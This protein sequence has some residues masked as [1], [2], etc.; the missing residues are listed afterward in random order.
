MKKI[1]ILS[2]LCT[3]PSAIKM[4]A[5]VL[6]LEKNPAFESVVCIT[7]QHR[8]M[9]DQVLNLFEIKSDYNLNIMQ[10]NQDLYSITAN[11]LNGLKPILTDLKPDCVI[12]QGDTTSMM[13]A[14]LAAFYQKIPVAHVEAGLRTNN[15]YAPYPEEVN[16][17]I[18]T[19]IVQL[20]FA[21]TEI[22]KNNLLRENVNPE[23]IFVTGNTVIDA[24]LWVRDKANKINDFSNCLG[25]TI[26]NLINHN[27]N[28]ILI[29]CHRRESFGDGFQ[30][31][32][33][34][35]KTL[36]EKYPDWH[37]IYPVHLNPNVQKPVY[38]TL[39]SIAN[40][41][42][43]SPLE[44]VPFVYLMDKSKIIITDSGGIQEEAPSLGKP[45]LVTR[46][47]TE[48][49]EGVQ[50]GAVIL[51][52]TNTQ[53]IIKEAE[54]LMHDKARYAKMSTI[55]NP[56]GDGLSA[57]RIVQTLEKISKKT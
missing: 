38:E 3:R 45:V 2:I 21:P 19:R 4:A 28:I 29:T 1:K 13:A 46:D 30:N 24:L 35:F 15:I 10:P 53:N 52:G 36:A 55:R 34:A 12:V 50:A 14:A 43:I 23:N 56:Y 22:S 11:V 25:P 5:I 48:R 9:L 41:H 42:L 44:Y 17:A 8:E 47:V 57:L 16:R 20:N 39:A 40:F 51:I 27:K 6:A 33:L 32:C 26:Q 54:S 37:F 49:P 18:I 7:G 31:I